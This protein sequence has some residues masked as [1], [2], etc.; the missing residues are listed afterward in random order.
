MRLLIPM[1]SHLGVVTALR[2]TFLVFYV[3]YCFFTISTLPR[4]INLTVADMTM[5]SGMCVQVKDM[6][7]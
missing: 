5:A 7:T 6:M 4:P 3:R 1:Q 2:S